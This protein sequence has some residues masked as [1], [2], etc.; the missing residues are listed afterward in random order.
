MGQLRVVLADDHPFVL[1]GVKSALSKQQDMLIVGEAA[2]PA[3]AI[4]LLRTVPCDVFV[5]DLAMPEAD[6]A[7]E[8]GVRFVRRVRAGWPDLRV[9]VL[10]SLTNA[11]VLQT[12]IVDEA[13]SVINKKESLDDLVLAVRRA[14]VGRTLVSRTILDAVAEASSEPAAMLAPGTLTPK[15][16]EVIE[17]F[18]GGRPISE[19]ASLLDQDVRAI[20]RL[21]RLAMSKLGVKNDAGL[22]AYTKI[23]GQSE[24]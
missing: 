24:N 19:I 9:V 2:S 23:T 12:L 16:S 6:D 7:A 3:S 21:K 1:L 22:F 13:L 8:D 4:H 15:E 18:V 20:S 17:M 11:A 5:T 10:T 14:R